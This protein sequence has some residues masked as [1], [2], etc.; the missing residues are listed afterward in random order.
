[1]VLAVELLYIQMP[2]RIRVSTNRMEA[3][4]LTRTISS[5]NKQVK[6]EMCTDIE[7]MYIYTYMYIDFIIEQAGNY[8]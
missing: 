6:V 3:T 5:L 1:V 4:G 8:I 2:I 7:Y